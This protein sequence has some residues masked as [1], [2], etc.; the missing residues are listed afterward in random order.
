M[1]GR[2]IGRIERLEGKRPDEAGRAEF[3]AHLDRARARPLK[4]GETQEELDRAADPAWM[5]NYCRITRRADSA[6]PDLDSR[7][8]DS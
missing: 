6:S 2:I 1:P 5:A 8:I 7:A 3:W 4:W